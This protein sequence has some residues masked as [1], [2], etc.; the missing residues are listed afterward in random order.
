MLLDNILLIWNKNK[1]ITSP[2]TAHSNSSPSSFLKLTRAM[3]SIIWR[4]FKKYHSLLGKYVL[5]ISPVKR[6]VTLTYTY[7]LKSELLKFPK[8]YSLK[9]W[10]VGFRPSFNTLRM[11]KRAVPQQIKQNPNLN[12]QRFLHKLC[13]PNY[14]WR[15][16]STKVN[17]RND[18]ITWCVRVQKF[19]FNVLI[20]FQ[21]IVNL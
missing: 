7:Q 20:V 6:S 12:T 14:I 19:P 15:Q 21:I 4:R 3:L 5:I 2:M 13:I 9:N 8:G 18:V 1:N 17:L 10:S 16:L 11:P